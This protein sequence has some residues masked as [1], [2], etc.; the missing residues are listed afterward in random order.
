VDTA[1]YLDTSLSTADRVADLIAR[2]TLP[3]PRRSDR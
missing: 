2:M 1:A 3:D